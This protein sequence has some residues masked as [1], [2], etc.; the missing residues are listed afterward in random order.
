MKRCGVLLAGFGLMSV[1]VGC[2]D[3]VVGRAVPLFGTEITIN[4]RPVGSAVI[5]TGGG[6]ELILREPFGLE[7][8]GT[9]EVLAFGGLE[10]VS[11]TEGFD[12]VAGGLAAKAEGA[13][14]GVSVCDC[15]GLGFFF[16][17]KTGAVLELDFA[18]STARFLPALPTADVRLPFAAPPPQLPGFDTAFLN[19]TVEADDGARTVRALLDSGTTRSVLRRG[20]VTGVAPPGQPNRLD[21]RIA[22]PRLGTVAVRVELFDTPGLPDLIVGTD[23]LPAWADRWYFAYFDQG[24]EI[25]AVLREPVVDDS[26][27]AAARAR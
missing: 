19:V 6:Y 12:Y 17:R 22:E 9:A 13:L 2:G 15:N 5:D 21:V 4:D 20:I 27:T 3:A 26:G 11:V 18:R 16:F 14:V 23:V 10:S 7:L 24:G 8:V 1:S 25:R